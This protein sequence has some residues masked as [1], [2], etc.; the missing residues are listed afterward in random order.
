M[1]VGIMAN[2]KATLLL[3]ERLA[4]DAD[5][6]ASSLVWRVPRPVAGSTH[7]YKYSLAYVVRS[8][9]LMRYDNER[10]KGDH[11]HVGESELPYVFTT[12]EQLLTD[13]WSDI[14]RLRKTS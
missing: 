11:R 13:F 10:G 4:L 9:C 3:K 12:P 2:M 14:D 7:L 6:F 8:V 5:S 1:R